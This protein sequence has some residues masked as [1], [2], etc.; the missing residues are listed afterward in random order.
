MTSKTI[1]EQARE[2]CDKGDYHELRAL[3]INNP[4]L[5][6]QTDESGATL[7]ICL[8]DYPGHRPNAARTARVLLNAGAKVD[9]RRDRKN[10]TAL[11]GAMSTNEWDLARVLLEFGASLQAPLGFT[12]GR[13]IDFANELCSSTEGDREKNPELAKLVYQYS[14]ITLPRAGTGRKKR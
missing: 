8:I 4:R 10:G 3:L 12:R 6:N 11:S 13:V 2:L 5:V 9:F 7:L 14:G 1:F